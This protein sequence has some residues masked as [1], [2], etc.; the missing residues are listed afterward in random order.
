[1]LYEIISHHYLNKKR[2]TKPYSISTNKKLL[3]LATGTSANEY[4]NADKKGEQFSEYDILV[5][6][7]SIYKMEEE[8]F[9]LKPRYFAACDSVYWGNDKT[10]SV[11]KNVVR[12]TYLRTKEVL[13]KVDWDMYLITTIHE[14]FDFNNKHIHIIRLNASVYNSGK[15][16]D[17][18]LYKGNFCN[19]GLYNVA[20]LAIYFGITF[21]YKKIGIAGM[22]FDFIKNLYCDDKCRVGLCAEHQYDKEGQAKIEVVFEPEKKGT[23]NGSVIAKYLYDTADTFAAFGK[24]GEYADRQ[25]CKILNYSKRSLVDC[26]EKK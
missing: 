16:R 14:K 4:W 21:K 17:Y 1:M 19:P 9:N 26:Y 24:L 25:G 13:E 11:T 10:A 15:E 20:Q 2:V 5:M 18:K 12:E 23:V 7:R 8:I 6:N 22:D 3:I